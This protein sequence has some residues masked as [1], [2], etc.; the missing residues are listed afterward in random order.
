MP[1]RPVEVDDALLRLTDPAHGSAELR[2]LV[3]E[4]MTV[5]GE[6]VALRTY[7]SS[8]DVH[9][10]SVS[11]PW[12]IRCGSYTGLTIAFSANGA[13]DASGLSVHVASARPTAEQC[14]PIALSLAA[15]VR[16]VLTEAR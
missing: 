1:S 15:V 10:I 12:M 4:R 14:V 9:V 7:L 3:L 6:F 16:S 13:D 8:E 5:S 11:T 2:R